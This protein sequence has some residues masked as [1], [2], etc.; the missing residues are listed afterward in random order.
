MGQKTPPLTSKE[1]SLILLQAVILHSSRVLCTI[2]V[3]LLGG[4]KVG[5]KARLVRPAAASRRAW[6]VPAKCWTRV[7]RCGGRGERGTPTRRPRDRRDHAGPGRAIRR[8]ISLLRRPLIGGL[9]AHGRGSAERAVSRAL[10][11][12]HSAGCK[13]A[14]DGAAGPGR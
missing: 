5:R 3:N 6:I 14:P 11:L 12:V 7:G 8:H 1:A 13:A 10:G 9:P 2:L 4:K